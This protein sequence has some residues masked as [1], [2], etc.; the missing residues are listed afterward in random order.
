[1]KKTCPLCFHHCTL[2]E[3]QTGAC[4]ARGNRHGQIVPLNYGKLTALA[5]DPIEKSR[6]GTFIPAAGYCR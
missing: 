2:S 6:C 5:L 4:R 1:M 3:G